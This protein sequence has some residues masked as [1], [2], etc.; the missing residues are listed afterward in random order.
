MTEKCSPRWVKAGI[1]LVLVAL[2]AACYV[3][4]YFVISSKAAAQQIEVTPGRFLAI[5]SVKYAWLVRAYKP[6]ATIE[7]FV[8]GDHVAILV[9]EEA[10]WTSYPPL[11]F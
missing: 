2:L 6:M 7:S 1:G 10:G 9:E 5:R 3:A 8:T 4:S 11:D